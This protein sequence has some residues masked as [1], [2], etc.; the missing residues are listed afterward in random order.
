MEVLELRLTSLLI[1]LTTLSGCTT[2]R[3]IPIGHSRTP[4]VSGHGFSVSLGAVT[5][6]TRQLYLA[7][8]EDLGDSDTDSIAKGDDTQIRNSLTF[9]GLDF[10]GTIELLKEFALFFDNGK[11]GIQYQFLGD[12]RIDS[13]TGNFTAS[14]ILG[15]SFILKKG[16][17]ITLAKD[18]AKLDGKSESH[19]PMLGLVTGVRVFDGLGIG[20]Q[21]FVQNVIS[22]A[23]GEVEY[24]N[25][26]SDESFKNSFYDY[27]FGPLLY[28]GGENLDFV[29]APFWILVKD[30][31]EED[32]YE[33]FRIL[34]R[35]SYT[36]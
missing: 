16:D 10:V 29:I 22:K 23:S 9:H 21:G 8:E 28:G 2:F 27:G 5:T 33:Q 11:Y 1:L 18:D 34:I 24:E 36:F 25:E 20:V 12:P 30:P 7:E 31:I 15:Y 26:T 17:N 13:K 32:L 19:V 6:Q 14:M 35:L 3:D 4:E